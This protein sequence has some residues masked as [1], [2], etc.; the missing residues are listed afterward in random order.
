MWFNGTEKETKVIVPSKYL[1]V[2]F[3]TKFTLSSTVRMV[4]TDIKQ[5][6]KESKRSITDTEH[7]VTQ[8]NIPNGSLCVVN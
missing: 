3:L 7:T 6:R 4:F 2:L 8:H 5:K 1:V